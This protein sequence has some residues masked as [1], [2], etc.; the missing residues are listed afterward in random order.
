MQL[1][2]LDF[3]SFGM[4]HWKET[5]MDGIYMFSN[6]D[7]RQKH[8]FDLQRL[9]FKMLIEKKSIDLLIKNNISSKEKLIVNIICKLDAKALATRSDD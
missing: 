4:T 9:L 1:Y 5:H 7:V 3:H 2:E 8:P 6:D